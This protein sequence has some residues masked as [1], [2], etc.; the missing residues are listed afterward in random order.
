MTIPKLS[1]ATV[2]Q[3]A[4]T[5]SFQRGQEYYQQG[6]AQSLILR[7]MVLSAEVEGS[8]ALPYIVRCT[9]DANGIATTSCTCPYDWGGWCKHI[10]ATCLA[11]IHRPELI[12]ERPTLD[13]LLS[14]LDRD[15]L[16]ALL[17]KLVERQPSLV[18]VIEAQV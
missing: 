5:E 11:I 18:E 15:K 7:G 4:S 6:A 16:Q 10:V 8:D 3:C 17:F 12:E 13:T 14:G 1:E 9:F 2:R